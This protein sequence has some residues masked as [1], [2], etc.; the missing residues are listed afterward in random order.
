MLVTLDCCYS[1]AA[2]AQMTRGS[3]AAPLQ[4]GRGGAPDGTGLYILAAADATETAKEANGLGV[5][6]HHLVQ[7]IRTGAADTDHDGR[8]TVSELAEHLYREVPKDAAQTPIMTAHKTAGTFLVA[9]N[10]VVIEEQAERKAK[11]E[12]AAAEAVRQATLSAALKKLRE[13]VRFGSFGMTFGAEVETWILRQRKANEPGPQF[14]L[15]ESFAAGG[16]S[17]VEFHDAWRGRRQRA[18]LTAL[19]AR[20]R[21]RQQRERR[22]REPSRGRAGKGRA[23]RPS[24]RGRAARASR[25]GRT[26]EG[27][28]GRAGKG[29]TGKGRTR[30]G[31]RNGRSRR[32]RR[33]KAEEERAARKGPKGEA[34]RDRRREKAQSEA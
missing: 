11:E 6:T 15:V 4:A 30:E 27:R 21:G 19:E 3:I 13:H 24:A 1:G 2:G 16:L 25:R 23:E 34:A 26:R 5:F 28:D 33:E 8:I 29:G 17:A 31:D 9:Q 20:R 22:Q 10:P 14:G 7:G 32:G 12:A 18:E